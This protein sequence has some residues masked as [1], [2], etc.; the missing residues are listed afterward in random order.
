MWRRFVDQ[1]TDPIVGVLF[2]AAV[3]AGLVG[4]VKDAVVIGAVLVLNGVIGFVQEG[5]AEQALA[6]L[7][8]MLEQ[9]VTVR[10]DGRGV[11]VASVQLVVGDVVLLEAGDRVPADGRV[12]VA[13]AAAV[14]ES[15]LTG[16]SV[17]ID[18][19]A[20]SIEGMDLDLGDRVNELFM[21][22]TVVRGR[23]ELLV[24]ATGMATEVGRIATMLSA[25]VD[26]AT[27][28]EEQLERLGTRLVAI[29][30]VAVAVVFGL[31]LLRGTPLGEAALE[32]VALGVAAIPEGLPAVV[33]VTLAVGVAAMAREQAIVRRL[34][35]VETLGST[36]AICSDKTGTLTRN[37]MT[38]VAVWHAGV[39]VEV[40]DDRVEG[41]VATALGVGVLASDATLHR[42]GG[43]HVGDPTELAILVAARSVGVDTDRIRATA[44]RLAELP[45]DSATKLMATVVN[46]DAGLLLAV[47]GAPD[48]LLARCSQ[49]AAADGGWAMDDGTWTNIDEQLEDWASR[50]WRVLAIASRPLDGPAPDEPGEVADLVDNLRLEALVAMVDPPRDGVVE[51]VARCIGAGIR[52]RMITGDHPSTAAA[53]ARAV[54]I[55]GDVV[56]GAELEAMSDAELADRMDGI[57]VCAR[58]SPEHKVR[59]VDALHLRGDVVA[60]TGDGV[61]DAAALRRAD[62]GVA[63]GVAGTEVTKEAADVVL[64]DDNFTT[65]VTAVERG[66]AIH[67]NFTTFVRFQ[68]TTNLAAIATILIAGLVA[69]PSPFTAIQILFVNLIADGPP[70]MALGVD[71]A[72]PDV[73]S[74]PPGD[75]DASVL[76]LTVLRSLL[77]TA[78]LMTMATLTVVAVTPEVTRSTMAFTTFVLLQLGNV[79]AVRGG[80]HGVLHRHLFT[81]RWV[82]AAVALVLAVQVVVVHLPVAQGLFATTDLSGRQWTTAVA[83]GLLPL[84]LAELT[85]RATRLRRGSR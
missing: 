80:R 18:K 17:P 66:R 49:V 16:E 42:E 12:L 35:S 25:T 47:K 51:A 4:D 23:V 83:I 82:W 52:V 63:M 54:G 1:F 84:A 56:T 60:M 39:A 20:S 68:L 45:F 29:V 58:V 53:I 15:T 76:D 22:T 41:G 77:P 9:V 27:P 2:G 13:R 69:L 6:A 28:M 70:A 26:R 43:D 62:V 37:Q 75:R 46:H 78:L 21:N 14:D 7:E 57:G 59:V 81:N 40:N 3:L 24:T 33:T 85:A 5:R 8:R 32:A 34:A 79:L 55:R 72:R 67:D 71:R 44:P 10:R 48:A 30:A 64:A 38:P 36:T 50:G 74:R 73:M 65:I 61:N 31:A 11:D 19:R